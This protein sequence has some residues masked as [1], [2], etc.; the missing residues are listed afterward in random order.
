[1]VCDKVV[2]K[3]VCQRSWVAKWCVKDGV[4]NMVGDKVVCA[5]WSVTVCERWCVTK[6]CERLCVKDGVSKMV[7]EKSC[8]TKWCVKDG[9]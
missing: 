8:V 3:M 2:L 9:V 4:S 7:S 1:M 6:W 5:R